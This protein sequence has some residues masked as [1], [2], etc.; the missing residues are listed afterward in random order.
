[1]INAVLA[2]MLPIEKAVV[3]WAE[4]APGSVPLR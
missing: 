2:S 1:M 3:T 4:T